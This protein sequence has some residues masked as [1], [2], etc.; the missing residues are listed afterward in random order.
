VLN[1]LHDVHQQPGLLLDNH[2]RLALQEHLLTILLNALGPEGHA[3]NCLPKPSTR[4]HIVDRAIDFM[5]ARL[6]RNIE[7]KDI[8][9]ALRISPRTLRYSFEAIVGVSPTHYLL[10]RRLYGARCDL[11][12]PCLAGTVEEVAL[13]WG[14]WHMGRF[15]QHYRLTF[16]ERPSETCSRVQCSRQKI[17]SHEES[18]VTQSNTAPA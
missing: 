13:R 18:L 17:A 5:E 2:G 10:A 14:F 8:C 6:A 7:L 11:A 15:A 9:D 12:R 16:G 3:S 4:A 1:L